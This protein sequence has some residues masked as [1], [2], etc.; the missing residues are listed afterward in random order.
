MT[1]FGNILPGAAQVARHSVTLSRDA[2]KRLEWMDYYYRGRGHGNARLTCRHFGIP[3]QTLYRWL[4]R[5]NPKNLLTLESRSCRPRHC[6]TPQYSPQL[7]QRV[8]EFRR[9]YPRWGKDK[10]VILLRRDGFDT[11]ASTVGRI[12]KRLRDR[13]VLVDAIRPYGRMA[14]RVHKH[15]RVYAIRKPRGYV[16]EAP[17]DLVQVDTMDLR[18][19]PGKEFKHFTARDMISK[20]DVLGVASRATA[21]TAA[22]FLQ[23]I[24]ER[25][26]FGVRAVQ[27]DGGSEFYAEFEQACKDKQI[28]LFV[29][30][31][32][33]PKLNGCVERAH[34]THDEEFYQVYSMTYT[35][36]G[37]RAAQEG[38]EYTYNYERPHQ[39]LNYQTP[40]QYL[41][42]HYPHRKED[43]SPSY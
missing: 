13:G 40:V 43:V 10:L 2:K 5:Y 25:M 26:P 18:P 9:Q 7:S 38:W 33:S 28:R 37:I 22:A 3:P 12:L 6:R 42:T 14:S 20:Y 32:R 30:P 16:V 17:G 8:L 36:E 19:V 21:G 11:S 35:V 34:R 39:A 1:T 41:Q 4:R 15:P 23:E 27:V 24:Q 29:L 31:P